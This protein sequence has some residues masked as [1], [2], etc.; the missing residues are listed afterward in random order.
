MENRHRLCVS[1]SEA[2]AASS[3]AAGRVLALREGTPA[4][5]RVLEGTCEH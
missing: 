4:G 5:T 2:A 1:A 3:T